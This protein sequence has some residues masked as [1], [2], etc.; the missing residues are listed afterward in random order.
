M[1][2]YDRQRNMNR[3]G[4]RALKTKKEIEKK[5]VFNANG[6]LIQLPSRKAKEIIESNQK[7]LEK[8]I[9]LA[10]Y[11]MKENTSKLAELES[12]ENLMTTMASFQ[13]NSISASEIYESIEKPKQ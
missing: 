7:Q 3:E 4:L 1:I 6:V 12:N 5:V 8:T 13:L 9:D 11:R 10:R 2:E